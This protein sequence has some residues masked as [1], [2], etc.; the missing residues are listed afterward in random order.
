[1]K[2]ENL[3]PMDAEVTVD[4]EGY[5]QEDPEETTYYDLNGQEVSHAE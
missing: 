5:L 2:N 4:L 1:M 3:C